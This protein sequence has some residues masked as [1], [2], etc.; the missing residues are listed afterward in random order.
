MPVGRER[1]S[2]LIEAVRV[3][4]KR[5][6]SFVKKRKKAPAERVV[7][8]DHDE[9]IRNPHPLPGE[10]EG[11]VRLRA[12]FRGERLTGREDGQLDGL[13][14]NGKGGGE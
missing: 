5:K 6:K 7:D 14:K 9:N 8:R 11:G 12:R 3:Q 2:S 10:A 13:S 1:K 4:G